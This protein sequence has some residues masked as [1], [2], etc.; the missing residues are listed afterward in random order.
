MQLKL[1]YSVQNGGD[2]SAY[3]DF[4]ES[5]ELAEWDQDHMGDDRWG[6]NCSGVITL[7]SDSV[8]RCV[9]K[10]IVTKE[11]YFLDKYC[12]T[13]NKKNKSTFMAKFFPNG[14]PTFT[15]TTEK[16]KSPDYLNNRIFVDGKQVGEAFRLIANSGKV[17]EDYL[18]SQKA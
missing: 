8:I 9:D 4:M 16:V 10:K 7:E 17:F 11:S 1:Y 12:D 15:V 3:P 18:N 6:E 2:G 14:L 5:K 13:R